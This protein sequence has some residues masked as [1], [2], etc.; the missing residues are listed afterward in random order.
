M[1][2]FLGIGIKTLDNSGLQFYQTGVI[3]KV[4]EAIGMEHCNGLPTTTNVQV[5]LGTDK[6][7]SEA[8]ILDQLTFFC[9]MDDVVSDIKEN[10]RYLLFYHSVSQVYS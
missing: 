1:S 5:P 2:E 3:H 6:N 9:Y 10:N 4:L 8:N 7:G